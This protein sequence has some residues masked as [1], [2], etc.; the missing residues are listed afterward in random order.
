MPTRLQVAGLSKRQLAKLKSMAKSHGMTPQEFAREAIQD[1]LAAEEAE[2]A[3]E[4]EQAGVAG[5]AARTKTFDQI[6]EPLYNK[7]EEIGE[8]E[9]NQLVDRAK[10]RHHARAARKKR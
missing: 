2:E 8:D 6:L 1:R 3:G 4:A 5:E 9:L 10:A 7:N